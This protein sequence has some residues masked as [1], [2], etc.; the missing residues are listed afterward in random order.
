MGLVVTEKYLDGFAGGNTRIWLVL[1]GPAMI[2]YLC[3][4]MPNNQPK[5]G[6]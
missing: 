2:Y 3:K 6:V 5:P 1:V 4:E